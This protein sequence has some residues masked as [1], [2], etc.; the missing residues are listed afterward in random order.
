MSRVFLVT[1]IGMSTC[2]GFFACKGDSG[3]QGDPGGDGSSPDAPSTLDGGSDDGGS[4]DARLDTAYVAPLHDAMFAPDGARLPFC[5]LPGSIVFSQGTRT[6]V[7]GGD[8]PLDDLSWLTIPDGFC[9]HYFGRVPYA[10]QVRVAPGGELFVSSPVTG[11]TGGGNDGNQNIEVLPDDDFNGVADTSIEF[12]GGIRSVQG[13]LFNQGYF[14]YQDGPSIRRV[15][16]A[17]GDR[18]PKS[19][20]ELVVTIGAPQSGAHWPKVFD[21][22]ADGTL[23][24]SNGSDQGEA[25]MTTRPFHGGILAIDG[26]PGGRP[27]AKGFRNPIALRCRRDKDVCLAVELVL[28]YSGPLGGREKLAQVK[29]GDDWG[30]PCCATKGV[31]YGGVTYAD[32][33]PRQV[34][35]C[36]GVASE[37]NAFIV[38]HTPFGFDYEPGQGLW[39]GMWNG[40]ILVTLHGD[41]GTW[42]GARVVAI[43]TDP[44]TGLP[45]PSSETAGGN[46]MVDFATGWDTGQRS[47]GRPAAITFAPDGRLFVANDVDGN[48]VWI[49]PIGL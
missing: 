23:Y 42:V 7:P 31:P 3:S 39:P 12:I 5:E 44:V 24:V 2:L 33:M 15:A 9:V 35:D 20:P 37:S 41:F 27:M 6:V 32:T 25:C 34:P 29:D 19:A 49:S 11:T 40:R 30:F 22:A 47:H 21:V 10:R 45:L 13:I 48:I 14:Y 18:T 36:S 4:S 46:N 17:A 26:T 1:A 28:D 43:A 38:G 16:Y 8:A